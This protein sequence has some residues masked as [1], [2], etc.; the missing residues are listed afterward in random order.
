[1]QINSHPHRWLSTNRL[2]GVLV[3]DDQM[4]E[5][6][7]EWGNQGMDCVEGPL[8]RHVNISLNCQQSRITATLSPSPPSPPRRQGVLFSF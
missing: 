5:Q 2:A 3:K 4:T 6:Q 7:A 8:G 1:M